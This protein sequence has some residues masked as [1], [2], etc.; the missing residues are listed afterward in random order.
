M[1]KRN[2]KTIEKN[3]KNAPVKDIVWEGEEISVQSDTKLEEDK[4]TGQ[5]II[6]RVFDFAAN[7]EVFKQ[8]KP[9][10]Q[11]LFASHLQ[12]MRSLLWRDGLAP[13]EKVEPRLIF[14]KDKSSY[15]FIIPC[16]ATV[17]SVVIDK[18]QT[19]SQIVND[20]STNSNQ[21]SRVV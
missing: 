17:G 11:E 16:I 8:H 4:G 19:L 18:P 13:Y 21:I 5:A 14:S 12:G 20:T 10:A 6:L 15:R 1:A 7:P 9:T 3:A 2:F